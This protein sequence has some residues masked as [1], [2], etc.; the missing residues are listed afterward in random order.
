MAQDRL[1]LNH[2]PK[3]KIMLFV[4][5]TPKDQLRELEGGWRREGCGDCAVFIRKIKFL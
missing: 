4:L 5:F 3:E 2:M 1:T